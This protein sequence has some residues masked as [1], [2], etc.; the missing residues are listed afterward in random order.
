MRAYTKLGQKF[1]LLEF[2]DLTHALMSMQCFIQVKV[3]LKKKNM[4]V[5]IEKF[6][7]LALARNTTMLRHIIRFFAPLFV[8]WS[9][10]EG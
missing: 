5:P 2:Q 8:Q 6:W 10:T 4:V 1:S 9:L 3:N 7:S